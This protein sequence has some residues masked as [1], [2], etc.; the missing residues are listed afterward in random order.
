MERN[1]TSIYKTD[2][3]QPGRSN[4]ASFSREGNTLYMHVYFWPGETVSL[5]GLQNKV[6]SA[7]LLGS[8]KDVK[9]DQEE[10]RIR[11]TGLPS[12]APDDPV[13]TLALELDGEPK[14]DNIWVRKDRPRR[15]V[16]V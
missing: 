15:A 5:A 10:F 6:K 16:G 12:K 14:Q 4:Y 8:G 13:T 2:K 1:G 3:C 9:F 7:R 11:F